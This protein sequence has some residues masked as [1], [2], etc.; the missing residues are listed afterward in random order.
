[1]ISS[2]SGAATSVRYQNVTVDDSRSATGI[3]N[4]SSIPSNRTAKSELPARE[5]PGTAAVTLPDTT[6][7]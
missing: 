7:S 1:M 4:S 2:S 6:A 5:V 3:D